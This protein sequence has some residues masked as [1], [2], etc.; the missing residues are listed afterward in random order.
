MKRQNNI[1]T[2]AATT[3]TTTPL[4]EEEDEREDIT[5]LIKEDLKK[6]IIKATSLKQIP[7]ASSAE[8]ASSSDTAIPG[9]TTQ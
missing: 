2:T 1:P 7:S 8:G 9:T 5:M 6:L 4:K 3:S